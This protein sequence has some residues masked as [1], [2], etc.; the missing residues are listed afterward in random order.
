[1]RDDTG[2]L[3][4]MLDAIDK[5]ESYVGG[6]RDAYERDE[7]LQVWVIHHLQI[8][9]EA[10]SRISTELHESHPEVPWTKI[11]GMRN[12]LVHNYVGIDLN[13]VWQ[14]IERDL[15]ELR[16]KLERLLRDH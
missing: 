6:D 12:I 3:Q 9:G 14:V 7:L 16:P 4:D 8:L 2:R 10:A 1:M 11:I 13:L 15:P 5:I